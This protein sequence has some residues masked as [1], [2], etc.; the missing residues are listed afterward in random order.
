MIP[1]NKDRRWTLTLFGDQKFEITEE[2]KEYIVTAM[3]KGVK[4]I[5]LNRAIFTVSS[6][7]SIVYRG[8]DDNNYRDIDP[9]LKEN[10]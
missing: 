7:S 5:K 9:I 3:E 8:V 6:V 2:E 10:L 4:I 1:A